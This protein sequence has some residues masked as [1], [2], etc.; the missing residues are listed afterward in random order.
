MKLLTYKLQGD[1]KERLGLMCSFAFHRFIPIEDLGIHF[2]DMN[3]LIENIT[4]EQRKIMEQACD[5]PDRRLLRYED[6]VQCA[7]IPHP[8]QDMICLGMNFR[9]HAVE[10]SRFKKEQFDQERPYAVYFSKRVNEA[11]PDGGTIPSYPGLVDSLDYEAEL[12]VIIGKEAKNVKKED[13][14]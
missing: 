4:P 11:T 2:R 8:R 12:A 6:V 3:D 10:S 7:P 13:A 14:V 9:E 5:Q 1:V